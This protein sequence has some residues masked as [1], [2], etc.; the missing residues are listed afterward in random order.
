MKKKKPKE[1]KLRGDGFLEPL[2]DAIEA[3]P[4]FQDEYL[5]MSAQHIRETSPGLHAVMERIKAEN[6]DKP[7]TED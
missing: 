4:E 7:G 5:E 3:H 1:S 6:K 2:A